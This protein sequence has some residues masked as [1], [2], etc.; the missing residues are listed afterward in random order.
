MLRAFSNIP[1]FRRLVITFG[2]ATL[3]PILVILLLGN[4]SLQ[5]SELRSQAV[6]TSFDAQNIATQEQINLQ[7][8]N[9]LIQARFAQ[10]FAQGSLSLEGDPSSGKLTEDDVDA[11]ET[12]FSQALANY[13][14]N[15]QVATAKNM[16]T[17]RS[18]MNSD[19]PDHGQQVINNQLNAL[20]AV[21]QVDWPHY[22]AQVQKIL[23]DLTGNTFYQVAYADYYQSVLGF[24]DLK[25]H[26][27]QV[28][29]AATEMGT[30]V[31]QT[32]P[33]LIDPLIIYTTIA[34]IF[35]LLVIVAAGFLINATIVVPL[36]QLVA[37]TRRV[38]RG[39]TR[40][41]AN[42]AGRDEI[43]QVAN[44]INGMLDNILRLMQEAQSRHADLQAQIEQ[45]ISELS[46]VGEGNLRIQVQVASAELGMLA[47]SFNVMAEELNN[48]VVNVK[49]LA[50]GVQNA[51]LHAFGYMEQLVDNSD[52]QIQQI[53]HA[54]EEVGHVAVSSRQI[55]ER[56]QMLY[57]VADEARQAAHRG[58]KAVIQT[59]RGMDHINENVG[60]T[61]Q[62]VLSLGERSREI[63][64]IGEVISSIAQQTN[65]L[66]LDASIQA[67][68]A[69][70]H[71]KGFGAVAV[72]IRRLAERAKEQSALIVQ[73]VHNVLE[74]INAVTV[75]IQ[76]TKRDTAMGTQ[77]AQE[78]GKALDQLFSAVEHQ[79]GEI[80]ATNQ[81][82]I[83]QVQI[84]TRVAQIMQ[85]VS[86]S[87]RNSSEITK[88]VTQQMERL[89][90]L[91]GQL[92][93]SVEV[94]KLREQY[95]AYVE[96]SRGNGRSGSGQLAGSG[97]LVMNNSLPSPRRSITRG[98]GYSSSSNFPGQ[99]GANRGQQYRPS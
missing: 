28:V 49:I 67:A 77:I 71:G 31:T 44:S 43:G 60:S 72:D 97:P 70:D 65:R 80:E 84:S 56:A 59:V 86:D 36:N 1:I 95:P 52:T 55:A 26:W 61:S 33:S 16:S 99:N 64:S 6:H 85:H 32:G 25:N 30:T 63:S 87:S 18:I 37:L 2:I 22:K 15:Y 69:G 14:K 58:R 27:Q 92:L 4:F 62:K 50:R 5:A 10:V 91:A 29:D 42:I 34:L 39:E 94:F 17:I 51:T 89:A 9:A 57:N 8:L 74:E 47:S 98:S 73:I 93:S 83:E 35:T 19:A 48:L 53:M 20:N 41:R 54:T 21:V 45:M 76:E 90:Q 24:L 96:A 88:T 13:Q 23:Q 46:G 82:A 38:A 81:V 79:A 68:M 7:R 66:A 75:S 12:E 3:I 78:V 40:A 11:L